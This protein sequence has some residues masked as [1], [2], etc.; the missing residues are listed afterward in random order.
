MDKQ[1][2]KHIIQR[3]NNAGWEAYLAG[4]AVRDMLLGKEPSDYDV[5]TNASHDA[6]RR[7]FQDRNVSVAGLSF[8]ICIVDGIGVA[9]YRKSGCFDPHSPAGG[10]EPAKTL[11]DD[12]SM[13]DFTINAMAFCP[14]TGTLIDPF[15][16]A[17]DLNDRVIRFTGNP[18]DRIAE[19]PLRMVRACRF[20]ATFEGTFDE[21]SL[22]SMIR[23]SG[24]V[25]TVAPERLGLELY[26]AMACKKPSLFFHALHRTGALGHVSPGLESLYGHEGGGYHDETIDEHMAV[27]GDRLSRR[28]PLLRLAGYYHDVGKPVSAENR[29]GGLTFIGHEKKGAQMVADELSALRFSVK[30][31]EYVRALVA[32]HMR[33]LKPDDAP[34]TVRRLLKKLADDHVSWKDWLCLKIADIKGNRRKP[35]MTPG[36]IGHLVMKIYRE[37]HPP[38]GRAALSITALAVNG[39]DVMVLRGLSEGPAVGRVLNQVLDYVLDDPARNTRDELLRFITTL[40]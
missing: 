4:G 9:S 21:P 3:L 17:R 20:L 10:G 37:L 5:V 8:R 34:K 18:E 16:G 28:K 19:D 13:R 11:I 31:T 14:L 7:L 15:G 23:N 40:A 35:D 30:D 6:V 32:H 39:Q 24:R 1:K 38:E 22:E 27:V 25:A 29:D 33:T 36:D 26:K 2:A 12:L